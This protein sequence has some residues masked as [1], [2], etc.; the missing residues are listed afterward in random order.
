MSSIL[1]ES[2]L[3]RARAIVAIIL[4]VLLLLVSGCRARPTRAGE[5]IV[6][7]ADARA[8]QQILA[9]LTA[10]FLRDRGYPVEIRS[11]LQEE[12]MTRRALETGRVG[13]VWQETGHTWH[14]H[15]NHDQPITSETELFRR[16]KE[17]DILNRIVWLNPV[18]WSARMSLVVARETA[19][20]HR[21]ASITE[22]AQ[23]ISRTDPNLVLC[24]PEELYDTPWGIRGMERVY[25]FRFKGSLVRFMD[26]G[27][28]Y[29]GLLDSTCDVAVGYG[30]D[31]PP[32]G[33]ALV[34]LRDARAFFPASSL[35]PTVHVSVL[36]EYPEL[37]RLLAELTANL[38]AA[39]LARMEQQLVAGQGR[40]DRM[41]QQFLRDAEL[42]RR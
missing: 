11:G 19:A 30:R 1:C 22:L 18:N 34:A 42:V 26:H 3:R 8:S 36:G 7:A 12:W 23:H 6:I 13:L 14:N 24:V 33:G 41:A 40:V 2:E 4:L 38:D 17:Q 37:E 39:S 21:L 28:A 32:Y 15:L 29:Q 31:L 5:P 9:E 25:R 10:Q 35:A 20:E 27:E 16:V